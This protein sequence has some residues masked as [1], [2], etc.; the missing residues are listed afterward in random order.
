MLPNSVRTQLLQHKPF[1]VIGI[2]PPG[3]GKSTYLFELAK[4]LRCDLISA[5]DIQSA[6]GTDHSPEIDIRTSRAEALQ[7]IEYQLSTG[8]SVVIDD[9]HCFSKQRSVL[10]SL[11]R[12]WGVQ[13]VH[14]IWFV[15]PLAVCLQHAEDQRKQYVERTYETLADNSPSLDEGFD[16]LQLA[17]FIA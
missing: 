2:G 3:S 13:K 14:G 8:M 16:S 7:R 11:L 5:R 1:A 10:I 15:T 6:Y 12:Q 9:M 17:G 4:P